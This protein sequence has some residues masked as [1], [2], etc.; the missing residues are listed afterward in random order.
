M[1][2]LSAHEMSEFARVPRDREGLDN[3]AAMN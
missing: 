2:I 3:M 1:Y